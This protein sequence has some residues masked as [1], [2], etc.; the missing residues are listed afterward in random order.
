MK[1]TAS[2]PNGEKLYLMY[3]LESG[4]LWCNSSQQREYPPFSYDDLQ[5]IE[6][7]TPV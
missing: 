1:E 6:R 2:L 7:E 5:R 3:D 4:E